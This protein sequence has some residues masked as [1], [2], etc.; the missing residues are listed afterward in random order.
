[1]KAQCLRMHLSVEYSACTLLFAASRELIYNW[2]EKGP[3]KGEL[4]VI[5]EEFL[6]IAYRVSVKE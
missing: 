5:L 2:I 4:I 1:M 3:K 6:D